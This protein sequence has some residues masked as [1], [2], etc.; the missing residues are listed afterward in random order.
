MNHDPRGGA[1]SQQD[2]IGTQAR[3]HLAGIAVEVAP[4]S[5]QSAACA[6]KAGS[7]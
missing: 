4:L 2:C 5:A 1:D 3:E 6:G 7:L